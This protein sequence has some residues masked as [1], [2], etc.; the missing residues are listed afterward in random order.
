[1][2][3]IVKPEKKQPSRAVTKEKIETISKVSKPTLPEQSTSI[4]ESTKMTIQ[5]GSISTDIKSKFDQEALGTVGQGGASEIVLPPD[6]ESDGQEEP[7]LG[8]NKVQLNT[9]SMDEVIS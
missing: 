1:M 3:K 8:M 4:N 5:E 9:Q 7:N 6:M 2:P